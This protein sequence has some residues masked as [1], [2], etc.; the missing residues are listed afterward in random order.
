MDKTMCVVFK[1]GRKSYTVWGVRHFEY[2]ENKT[3]WIYTIGAIN[4]SRV[5]FVYRAKVT[6]AYTSSL[7]TS[8]TDPK[9]LQ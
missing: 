5:H 2:D 8:A 7:E 4:D 6:E 1:V 9:I 3:L